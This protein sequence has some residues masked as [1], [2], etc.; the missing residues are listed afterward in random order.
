MRGVKEMKKKVFLIGWF[1]FFLPLVSSADEEIK[2]MFPEYKQEKSA[3]GQMLYYWSG[4]EDGKGEY[5]EEN[6]RE[7][8]NKF[9]RQGYKV[10]QIEIWVDGKIESGNV[11]KL[12]VSVEGGGG[13]ISL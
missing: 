4:K 8:V 9:E 1:I 6:L 10:S 2:L 5:S 13:I 12:F 7:F 3:Q 11:T